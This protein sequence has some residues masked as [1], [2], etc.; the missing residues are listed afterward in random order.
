MKLDR[1]LD[2][3]A[4]RRSQA[5]PGLEVTALAYDSR[6]VVPGS[7]FF[8]VPGFKANGHDFITQVMEKGAA[9][10][11]VENWQEPH[12]G[13]PF[14]QI[15]VDDV[16]LAM[17]WAAANFYGHPSRRMDMVGV[18]GTNGKTTT[19][20]LID[21]ILRA[22]GRRTGLLGGI[23]YRL[24]G[25]SLP[26]ART[27]PESID[28]QAML[29]E[30]LSAGIGSAI[31]EVSSH[32]IDLCRVARLEFDV[33][34]FTNLTQDHL[35]LH[36]DMESYFASKRRLFTG[37][38]DSLDD[39]SHT[40]GIRPVAVINID[41]GFGR[42]LA[43]ELSMEG[44][45]VISFGL[46]PGARVSAARVGTRAGRTDFDLVTP[47]GTSQVRLA[48]PGEHNLSNALA[49]TAAA[50]ALGVPAADAARGLSHAGGP[51][52]RFESV[53]ADVPFRVIIDYA[54]NEDGLSKTLAAAREMTGARLI[55]VFGCPGER[56]RDKR[57]RMGEVAGAL[58]DLAILTTDDCY[59]ESPEEILDQTEPGLIRSGGRYLRIADRRQAIAA[60]L[61]AARGGDLV[62]I[63]GK[64]HETRQI[65]AAGAMP[66]SDRETVLEILSAGQGGK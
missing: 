9:A 10:T 21:S 52:G 6:R 63:A 22:T 60:A 5:S 61:D 14:P 18:T 26:A 57:P 55:T 33:A 23:E 32:G 49:A 29:A 12:Q 37:D 59:G 8:A 56:D 1:I 28:L 25:R 48:L 4:V 27:T 24:G 11:V 39:T 31:L 20:F 58:S 3:I 51:P 40:A 19:T 35:D 45:K 53:A 15:Q 41:D 43:R 42:R 54:H 46:D 30:M 36:G 65:M 44:G 47:E 50:L 62:V 16:R 64:G 66:F 7:L 34:V 17:A 38:L 2:G 13:A